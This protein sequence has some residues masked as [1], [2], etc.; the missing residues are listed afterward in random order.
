MHYFFEIKA[1]ISIGICPMRVPSIGTNY[2][3]EHGICV[4]RYPGL[5]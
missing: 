2:E 1:E 3:E 4:D 5:N